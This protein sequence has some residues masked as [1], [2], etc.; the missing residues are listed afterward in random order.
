M[1]IPFFIVD[2]EIPLSTHIQ[3]VTAYKP[4]TKATLDSYEYAM[5]ATG[6]QSIDTE[7][8]ADLWNHLAD[9]LGDKDHPKPYAAVAL[10]FKLIKANLK[11]HGVEIK[12]DLP[13]NTFN[14]KLNLRLKEHIV[15]YTPAEISKLLK[16][17]RENHFEL[18]KL[19]LML[20]YSG[21]RVSAAYGV[22]FSDLAYVE[23]A[24][25]YAYR[26]KSK[27]IGYSAFL[28]AYAVEQ[29]KLYNVSK[30][31]LV[32]NFRQSDYSSTFANYY[33]AL[34]TRI[35]I[36]EGI[37]KPNEN[38]SIFHSLRHS[39]SK[40]LTSSGVRD[41][42]LALLMGHLPQKSMAW[43]T[44]ANDGSRDVPNE[45]T[46]SLAKVYAGTKLNSWRVFD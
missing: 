32:V 6:I 16:A 21:L 19:L 34:L 8:L 30:S 15:A 40:A 28:P 46:E 26:V 41:D 3:H 18:T 27:K 10:L 31:P 45:L 42:N 37:G 2:M 35:L 17:V 14:A 36:K 22:C 12:E 5:S 38:I 20:T 24:G 9:L 29:L 44:Y 7:K 4:V 43:K 11:L 1:L 33:R 25:V 23:S 39:F 13:F